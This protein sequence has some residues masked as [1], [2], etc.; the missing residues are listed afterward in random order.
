[1]LPSGKNILAILV[2]LLA[3]QE[4]IEIK[5]ELIKGVNT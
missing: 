2:D 4:G 5:Y 1:M 3:D